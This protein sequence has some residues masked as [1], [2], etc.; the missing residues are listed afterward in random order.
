MPLWHYLFATEGYNNRLKNLVGHSH[1][2]IHKLIKIIRQEL[3]IDA[4]KVQQ[5]A[6]GH[7][8]LNGKKNISKYERN[9]TQ[10]MP[11]LRQRSKNS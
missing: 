6:I 1:P 7:A 9:I 2:G 10:F 4:T 11:Q 5:A 8:Q 3:V